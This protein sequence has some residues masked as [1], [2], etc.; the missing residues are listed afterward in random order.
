MGALLAP[1]I[2]TPSSTL[3]P[4]LHTH[5]FLHTHSLPLYPHS[6]LITHPMR[7]QN[8]QVSTLMSSRVKRRRDRRRTVYCQE[9]LL[10]LRSLCRRV[11]S[12]SMQVISRGE[13]EEREIE[14]GGPPPP[15][16]PLPSLSLAPIFVPPSHL[17]SLPLFHLSSLASFITPIPL[18]PLLPILLPA[19]G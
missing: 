14:M 19:G 7:R 11:S 1:S 13:G 16:L 15:T 9:L 4:S 8:V 17:S 10:Q 3:P 12:L 2:L 5:S 6:L 18:P